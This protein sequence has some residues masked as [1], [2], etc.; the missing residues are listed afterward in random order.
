[1]GDG[2]RLG[3][4][5]DRKGGSGGQDHLGFLLEHPSNPLGAVGIAERR[6]DAALEG[7]LKLQVAEAGNQL[8]GAE[9]LVVG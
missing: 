4:R 3:G 7:G 2:L 1:M 9:N 5:I 6:L 8:P